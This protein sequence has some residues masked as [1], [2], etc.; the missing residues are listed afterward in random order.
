MEP[1]VDKPDY[2]KERIKFETEFFKQL[3][4]LFLLVASGTTTIFVRF[5]NNVNWL[6]GLVIL[7]GIIVSAAIIAVLRQKH[8]VIYK[9]INDLNRTEP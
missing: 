7:T 1:T 3:A 5:V 6:D 4:T 2:I 8:K 9:L